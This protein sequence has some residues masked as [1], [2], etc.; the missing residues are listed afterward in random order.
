MLGADAEADTQ[1]RAI[2]FDAVIELDRWLEVRIGQENDR[3]WRAHYRLARHRI[4]QVRRD[5]AALDGIVPVESPPGSP[6][7]DTGAPRSS[8]G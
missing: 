8:K 7:G 1:V 3:H 5:P 6:V 4:E 2:A